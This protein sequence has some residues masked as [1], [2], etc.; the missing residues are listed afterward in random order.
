MRSG[1]FQ[2]VC[3][4]HCA[5]K[6]NEATQDCREVNKLSN[7]FSVFFLAFKLLTMVAAMTAWEIALHFCKLTD[8][9]DVRCGC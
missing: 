7:I 3:G 4:R 6:K 1:P 2:S 5:N 8:R 9:T